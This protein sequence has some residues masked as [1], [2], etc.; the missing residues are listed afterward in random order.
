MKRLLVVVTGEPAEPVAARHGDFVRILERALGPRFER[1]VRVLDA[2]REALGGAAQNADGLVITGSAAHVHEREP[3]VVATEEWLAREVGDGRPVLGLCFGHQLLA[4]AL[5]GEVTSN[6]RGR[7]M[8][9]VTLERLADDPILAGIPPRFSANT[10]HQDTVARLPEGA[11]TLA[12]SELDDHQ[13]VRFREGSY[14]VQFH[15]EFDRAI[16]RGYVEARRD[17]LREER[18]DVEQLL[19]DACDTPDAARV[20]A[21]FL[22]LLP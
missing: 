18:R 17:A 12:R 2:R 1:S 22:A 11:R 16:M 14:G 5:G 9:T 4:S 19:G 6:P 15:P 21:N 8:G 7:E 3:W 20:L 10:C 13:C